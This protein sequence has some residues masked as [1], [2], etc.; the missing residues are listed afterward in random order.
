MKNKYLFSIVILT[1]FLIILIGNVNATN[2]S[3]LSGTSQTL[4]GNQTYRTVYL[5][6][7]AAININAS[8]GY[9]NITANNITIDN[10][11]RINGVGL[12]NFTGGVGSGSGGTI[13]QGPGN[14]TGGSAAS[15]SG[16]AGAGYGGAGGS[17][18]LT[19]GGGVAYGSNS[20]FYERTMG[21]GGGGGGF[22]RFGMCCVRWS[23]LPC[24]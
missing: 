6:N 24:Q 10:T 16:G 1:L 19:G 11:S 15:V 20:T 14:G 12:S 7:G 17:G 8:I 23:P 9:L 22:T 21:S 5:S 2:I 4:G 18:Y 13:G 3:I